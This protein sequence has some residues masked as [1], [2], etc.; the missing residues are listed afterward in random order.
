M[1]I[2][3]I[4]DLEEKDAKSAAGAHRKIAM[5]GCSKQWLHAIRQ[6]V[7]H[8]ETTT[9]AKE[10]ETEPTSVPLETQENLLPTH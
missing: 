8:M 9:S 3:F 7:M 6:I 5:M 2:Q 10:E 4:S 1:L